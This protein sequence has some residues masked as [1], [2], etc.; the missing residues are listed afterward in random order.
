MDLDNWVRSRP[1]RPRLAMVIYDCDGVLIDSEPLCDRVLADILT[2][3]GWPMT[4]AE[5][6]RRFI[7]LSFYDVQPMVEARIGRALGPSWIDEVVERVVAVMA[8]EVEAVPGAA[9]AL[10]ATTA[11]GLPWRIASNSSHEEMAAKFHRTGLTATVAGRLH[12]AQD[13]VARGGRGKPAPD[14]Y[15]AAAAAQQVAP[16]ACLVIEDSV[17]GVRAAIAAGMT[18]LGFSPDHDGARLRDLGAVP[19]HSMYALPDIL[20]RL[21][22]NPV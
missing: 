10:A 13:I 1:L 6:H 19:F 4:A 20:R 9:D 8:V 18:C 21:L 12:S 17:A 2:D 16:A 22:E 11:L 14:I 5:S 15:L 7:G 3:L